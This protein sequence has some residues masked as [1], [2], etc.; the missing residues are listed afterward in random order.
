MADPIPL[1][2]RGNPHWGKPIPPVPA[3]L[4]E[5]EKAAKRLRLT[6]ETYASSRELREWC[7]L[8]KDRH[9]VPEWLLAYWRILV[10]PDTA[11]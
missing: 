1:R 6:K 7:E 2:R 10:E 5:F 3:T 4:T 9:Y 8:N 11:A